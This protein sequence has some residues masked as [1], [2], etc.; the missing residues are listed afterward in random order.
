MKLQPHRRA[1]ENPAWPASLVPERL[2]D[3]EHMTPY[4]LTDGSV[5]EERYRRLVELVPE[6]QIFYAMK[7]NPTPEVLSTLVALGSGFEIASFYELDRALAAGARAA[8]VLY[9]N[10]V[11]PADHIAAAFGRGV[12]RFAFDSEGELRKL[13]KH[14]PGSSVYVRLTVD[15]NRSLFPL[16]KKFGATVDDATRLLI[17][18]SELGLTPYGLTFHVGSQCTDPRAWRSAIARCAI[19]MRELDQQGIRLEMLNLGGGLPARYVDP[20]PPI[21]TITDGLVRALHQLPYAPRLLCAEPGR[22]LV[23]ESS[24]LVT[25]VIGV[26]SRGTERWAYVDVGGYNGIMEAI[27]TGGRWHFPLDTSRPDHASTPHVSFTVTGPT[28]DSSDT[29]FRDVLLPSTLAEGDRLYIGSAGAYTLSY[30]SHFNGFP[31]P[32]PI[33]IG[34]AALAG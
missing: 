3:L 7:C 8:D 26:A 17:L 21:D 27:Q 2:D 19:V 11:K 33:F 20:V 9:S 15:D 14:A 34:A 10:T 6:L 31:P 24:V 18:A 22:Y 28:C 23:A 4:L 16:A 32:T 25:T 13:A 1:I 12:R 5:I 30:A 29:I